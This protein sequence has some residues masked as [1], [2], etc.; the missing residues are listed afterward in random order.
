VTG[1]PFATLPSHSRA[2]SVRG[3][4]CAPGIDGSVLPVHFP[5][6][7]LHG[8]ACITHFLAERL[9][10]LVNG[11]GRMPSLGREKEISGETR[12]PPILRGGQGCG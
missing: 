4:A 5:A 9:L 8:S 6:L 12:D 1:R 7:A 3:G 11:V 10:K 2:S